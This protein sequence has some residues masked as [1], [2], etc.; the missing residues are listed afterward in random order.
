MRC[1]RDISKC[2][3]SLQEEFIACD[4][5]AAC[6]PKLQP[7]WTDEGQLYIEIQTNGNKNLSKFPSFFPERVSSSLHGPK[8]IFKVSGPTGQMIWIRG[9]LTSLDGRNIR[10]AID[11][12]DTSLEAPQDYMTLL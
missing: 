5:K 8:I 10:E 4:E 1:N 11:N 3:M 6:M 12:R 7:I 2:G 9:G